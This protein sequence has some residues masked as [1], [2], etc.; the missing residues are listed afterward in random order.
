M[1]QEELPL[2]AALVVERLHVGN[3]TCEGLEKVEFAHGAFS[4]LH[5]SYA[6][7]VA[8]GSLLSLHAGTVISLGTPIS[9]SPSTELMGSP[10]GA[11]FPLLP[12]HVGNSAFDVNFSACLGVL[13]RVSAATATCAGPL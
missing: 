5:S 3:Q 9:H 8:L 10:H 12:T 6:A 13:V 7:K 1:V 4:I 11:T 2:R